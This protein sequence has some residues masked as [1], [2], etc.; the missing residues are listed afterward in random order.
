MTID[1]ARLLIR[2]PIIVEGGSTACRLAAV[3]GLREDVSI[4]VLES[5]LENNGVT[6]G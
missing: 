2:S 1:G 5:R 4:L 3:I 6:W